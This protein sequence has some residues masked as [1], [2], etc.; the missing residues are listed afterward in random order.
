VGH[1]RGGGPRRLG[2]HWPKKF[3][4]APA[5]VAGALAPAALALA[6]AALAVTPL[7]LT[8]LPLTSRPLTSLV[9]SSAGG[10]IPAL[11]S[12]L[13]DVKASSHGLSITLSVVPS[14]AAAGATVQVNL[15]LAARAANGAL[16]YMVRFGDGSVHA[17]AIPMYCL[18]GPGR[19]EHQSWRLTHRYAHAGTYRVS[20]VGYANCGPDHASVTSLVTIS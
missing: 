4:L 10:V 20:A 5:V 3:R 8:S 14:R 11:T 15:D 12:R 18:A 6:P 7:P 17:N 2:R 19:P 1:L 16:G 9:G 13:P